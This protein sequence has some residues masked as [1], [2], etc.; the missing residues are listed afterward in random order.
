MDDP[1]LAFA[2]SNSL[3]L[4]SALRVITRAVGALAIANTASSKLRRDFEDVFCA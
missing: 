4:P 3:G 2:P 1:S